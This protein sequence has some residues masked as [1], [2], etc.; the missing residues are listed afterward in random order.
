[1]CREWLT[2]RVYE[3]KVGEIEVGLAGGGWTES[4]SVQSKLTR[5]GR[6]KYL[7]REQWRD[8]VNCTKLV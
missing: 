1:M 8:F 6:W 2:R 4:K 5:A 7:H 3:L